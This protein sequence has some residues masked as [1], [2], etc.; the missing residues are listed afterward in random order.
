MTNI[1]VEERH[2]WLGSSEAGILFDVSPYSSMFELWHQKAGLIP[3]V[4]LDGAER[5]EA[6]RWLEPAIAAWAQHKWQWPL[7]KVT[8][9]LR[10]PTIARMGASLDFETHDGIP[11]EIKNVDGLQF[12]L[13]DWAAEEGPDIL[14]DAPASILLQV[15]HQLACRPEA[16]YGWLVAC[17]GG[18]RLMRMQVDR[19]P[20]VVTA[21]EEA[22]DE[23]WASV[24]AGT[25]PP[26]NFAQDANAISQL[27]RDAVGPEE[28][29]DMSGNNHL[30]V[31]C[32]RYDE[33]RAAMKAADGDRT[34]ARAEILTIIERRRKV[35]CNGWRISAGTVAGGL[36]KAFERRPYR[37]VLITAAKEE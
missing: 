12:H 15:Q 32:K 4:S 18:N 27:Y 30:T 21:I 20:N 10:H 17:V 29:E 37:N 2:L 35:T 5:I 14:T 34:A 7:R 26:P 1:P 22:V 25:P 3:A 11:V 31:L 36:V 6:G 23:F 19:A 28:A 33:A 16:P 13:K 9:Y 8:D 24:D